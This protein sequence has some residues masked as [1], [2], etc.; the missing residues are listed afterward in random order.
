MKLFLCLVTPLLLVVFHHCSTAE[1]VTSDQTKSPA[2][3]T[4][5]I[6]SLPAPKDEEIRK[7]TADGWRNPYVIAYTDGYELILPDQERSTAHL[8]LNDL[9]NRLLDLPSERWPLGGVVAVQEIGLRSPGDDSKIASN[10][11][12]LKLMLESHKLRADAWPSA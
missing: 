6:D 10:L 1:K 2:R 9:E 8:T 3:S 4:R 7:Q 5:V 12:V 11:R